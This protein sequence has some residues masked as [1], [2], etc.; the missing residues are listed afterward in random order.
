[1]KP[2][3]SLCPNRSDAPVEWWAAYAR[4]QV[5]EQSIVRVEAWLDKHDDLLQRPLIAR[6]FDSKWGALILAHWHAQT[7]LRLDDRDLHPVLV[8]AVVRLVCEW[9]RRDILSLAALTSWLTDGDLLDPRTLSQPG[10]EAL[11]RAWSPF[12]ERAPLL[13]GAGYS[14]D[15][16]TQT[17]ESDADLV[18]IRVL[19]NL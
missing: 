5:G 14:L 10:R 11:V 1:M 19:R 6:R 8:V 13:R 2:H 3:H 7:Q 15:E 16:A 4:S 12:D 18:A 17:T 9:L